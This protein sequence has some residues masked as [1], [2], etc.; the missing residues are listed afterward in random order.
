MITTKLQ[1]VHTHTQYLKIE[2]MFFDGT[3]K[4]KLKHTPNICSNYIYKALQ[5][6]F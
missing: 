3:M 4:L 2:E 6:K 5:Q 1:C